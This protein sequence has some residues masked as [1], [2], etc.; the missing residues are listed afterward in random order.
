MR[1][2]VSFQ[3]TDRF[4]NDTAGSGQ[5]NSRRC[6][7]TAR[8]ACSITRSSCDLKV[9]RQGRKRGKRRLPASDSSS[10]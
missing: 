2:M 6:C 9:I 5:G 8:Q 4:G 3:L 10:L 1:A 7:A